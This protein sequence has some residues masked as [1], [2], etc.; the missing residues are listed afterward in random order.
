MDQKVYNGGTGPLAPDIIK[1]A[2]ESNG[3]VIE[4]G[5][6]TGNGSTLMIQEG[7]EEHTNPLHVSVDW[8][9]RLSDDDKPKNP[10]W[11]M[12]IG[13]SRE[14]STLE[15]VLITSQERRPGLIFIDTD[16]NYN[17]MK[18]ELELWGQIATDDTVWLF[19]DTWMYGPPNIEMVSTIINY[20]EVN[21]WKYDDLRTD[22]HGLG[23]MRK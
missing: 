12:V 8:E 9:D 4:L 13:D 19:H 2:Q 15:K 5:I 18:A 6:Y 21:G 10:W 20:A 3:F 1:A 7:L 11:H 22:S 16:H 14:F 17:Q 23:R